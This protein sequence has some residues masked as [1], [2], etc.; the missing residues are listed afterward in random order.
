MTEVRIEHDLVGMRRQHTD[1]QCR[2][3]AAYNEC[4]RPA[5]GRPPPVGCGEAS[6]D[7]H[8][9]RPAATRL[10]SCFRLSRALP[11]GQ[12]W[13][14]SHWDLSLPQVDCT[15]NDPVANVMF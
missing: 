11:S 12:A 15:A 9:N 3:A 1:R 13:V 6:Y 8:R 5:H 7:A 4:A 2:G 10:L 14:I